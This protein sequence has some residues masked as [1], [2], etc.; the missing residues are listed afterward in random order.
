MRAPDAATYAFLE[1]RPYAPS[2]A[3]WDDA[4]AYWRTLPTDAD[5]V[6]D[7][8]IALDVSVLAPQ[9]TWGTSPQ[10]ALGIDGRVPDPD[11]ALD[12]GERQRLAKCLDYMGLRAGAALQ[13]VAID[14]VFIGSC[15]NGRIEDLR[16]AAQVL[17]GR[18]VARG[19]DAI[20]VPGSTA[21]RRQ[22]E[23]EGLDR[24]FIDAGLAWREAGCSMCVAMNA[25]RLAPGERCAS[26]SNR[27]FEGR[28]GRDGRTH[29][30]SPASAAA[31][32]ILGHL[33]DVREVAA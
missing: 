5:A 15:T 23:T 30:M 14:K 26:T 2:P 32:A 19:V 22:A 18:K 33:A 13:D 20:V 9:V 17:A 27:N 16:E 1:G 7:K 24:I 12:E 6:Y 4:L 29:L 10:D 25:D 31:S 21:V 8:A 11:D 3:M 28:Q